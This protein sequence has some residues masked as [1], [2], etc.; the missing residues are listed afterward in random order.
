MECDCNYV[1]RS[2]LHYLLT[3]KSYLQFW[4]QTNA[5]PDNP[6]VV[7]VA[8][9]IPGSDGNQEQNRV[10]VVDVPVQ[11]QAHGQEDQAVATQWLSPTPGIL[12]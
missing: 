11:A 3:T 5:Y 6:M 7:Q 9:P 8:F 10:D 4:H 12:A 2:E 1:I